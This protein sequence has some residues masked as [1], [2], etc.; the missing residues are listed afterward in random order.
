MK[1]IIISTTM[2]ATLFSVQASAAME[3][4]IGIDAAYSNMDIKSTASVVSGTATAS[5]V[6]LSAGDSFSYT[7]DG[8]DT[9]PV[10][11]LG[12]IIDDTHRAYIKYGSWKDQG[13]KVVNTTANYDYL[14]KLNNTKL[15]PFIG[16]NAGYT[17]VEDEFDKMNGMTYGIQAGAIYP[18]GDGFE[19]EVNAGYSGY[20]V[21]K[22][23]TISPPN[24]TSSGVTFNNFVGSVKFEAESSTF[25][26]A[27]INYRF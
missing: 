18:L 25:I 17:K 3:G 2:V 7:S 11:K 15:V 8:S 4:F 12:V 16:V 14:I 22:T 6:T 24:G 27:G 23:Y 5:G 20:N 10:I 13:V 26:S 9:A 21:D 1:K 19:F